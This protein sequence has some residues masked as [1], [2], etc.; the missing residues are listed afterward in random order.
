MRWLLLALALAVC[1]CQNTDTLWRLDEDRAGYVLH[2]EDAG[3]GKFTAKFVSGD[4]RGL[5]LR[6][7]DESN[8]NVVVA[9]TLWLE[10]D[11]GG[12]IR[13]GMLKRVVSS[14]LDR[15]SYRASAA[16]WYVVEGGHVRLDDKREGNFD[17]RYTSGDGSHHL[18]GDIVPPSA[19]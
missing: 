11:T 3:D 13:K 1:A 8:H 5:E 4:G 16:K 12:T 18:R 10:I 19:K 9:N 6:N 7:I 17:L 14:D 2:H 15:G